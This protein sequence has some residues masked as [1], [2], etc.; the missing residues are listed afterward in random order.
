LAV[1]D[2]VVSYVEYGGPDRLGSMGFASE[3]ST[4]GASNSPVAVDAQPR[5]F[6]LN[7]VYR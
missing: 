4:K 7:D 2:V 3:D 5:G 1:P 6:L